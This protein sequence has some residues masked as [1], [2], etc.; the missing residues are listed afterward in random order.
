[1]KNEIDVRKLRT[2]HSETMGK[3]CAFT[4]MIYLL[5]ESADSLMVDVN[6]MLKNL[7][8]QVSKEEKVKLVQAINLGKR[9]SFL[10]SDMAK[11]VYA[12]DSSDIALEE[13]DEIYDLIKLIMDRVGGDAEKLIEIK[14]LIKI[15][16]E[17]KYGYYKEGK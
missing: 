11:H 2:E 1:M 3:A 16:F 4:S 7:K 14:N 10:I 17:S 5:I 12:I 8:V 13:S 9:L 6:S 15:N